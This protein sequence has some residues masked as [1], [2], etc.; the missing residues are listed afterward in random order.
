MTRPSIATRG[1][2][3]AEGFT[4]T[5]L[6]VVITIIIVMISILVPAIGG[7]RNAA[8][9]SSSQALMSSINSAVAQFRAAE[10]RLPGYFSAKQLG[11]SRNIT[12][13]MTEGNTIGLSAMENA[14]LDLAGGVHD[15]QTAS[16]PYPSDGTEDLI[17][18]GVGPAD[19]FRVIVQRSAIGGTE[20]PGYLDLPEGFVDMGE[21]NDGRAGSNRNLKLMPRL[22]DAWGSPIL[23]WSRDEYAG[24]SPLVAGYESDD[25]DDAAMFYWASNSAMV[26]GRRLGDSKKNQYDESALSSRATSEEKLKLSLAAI[27]GHPAFPD[28]ES[29]NGEP[30]PAQPRGDVILHSAG[31][32]SIYLSRKG[33]KFDEYHYVPDGL[34]VGGAAWV[35]DDTGFIDDTD[36][37]LLSGS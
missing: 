34:D 8:K 13:S 2:S 23:M 9:R 17:T 5:E 28:P 1:R 27:V 33:D 35:N 7:A 12:I 19:E 18:V 25:P 20:S 31:Q 29:I 36:D 3:R 32:D 14:L 15:D 37:I 10:R 26:N 16:P 6:L 4:L 21:L 22:V 11:N 30:L 24:N